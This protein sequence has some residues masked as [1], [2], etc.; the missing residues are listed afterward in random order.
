MPDDP[1]QLILSRRAKF[2]AAALATAGLATGGSAVRAAPASDAA[3]APGS[4]DASADGARVPWIWVGND[5][6]QGRDEARG[7]EEAWSA[8]DRGMALARFMS[9]FRSYQDRS[10]LRRIIDICGSLDDHAA[11]VRA[12]TRFVEPPEVQRVLTTAEREEIARASE[13]QRKKTAALTIT[14]NVDDAWIQVDGM[15]VGRAPLAEPVLV[16]PGTHRVTVG[17]NGLEVTRSI[18]VPR[19]EASQAYVEWNANV[20]VPAICLSPSYRRPSSCACDTPGRSG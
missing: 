19:P 8:G 13:A 7:A 20:G 2:V 10:V 11:A 9:S 5:P 3:V 17:A 4:S 15:V 6:A 18:D 1:K 12:C 14:T 16:N